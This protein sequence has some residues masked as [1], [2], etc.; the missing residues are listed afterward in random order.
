VENFVV[1]NTLQP[2]NVKFWVNIN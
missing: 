2:L 1:E